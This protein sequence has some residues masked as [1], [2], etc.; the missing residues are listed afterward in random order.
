[1]EQGRVR[2]VGAPAELIAAYT[3]EARQETRPPAELHPA[4]RLAAAA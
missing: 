4:D 3:A 1:M 2:A